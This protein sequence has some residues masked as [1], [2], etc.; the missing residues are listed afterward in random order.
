ML[1]ITVYYDEK[2]GIQ[3]ISNT[4][5]DLRPT[6]ENGEVYRDAEYKRLEKLSLLSGIDLL[7]KEEIPLVSE[8]HKSA[9]FIEFLKILEGKYPIIPSLTVPKSKNRCN[10][11][12]I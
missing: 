10:A 9:D 7:T 6:A 11:L 4:A 12:N 3:A 2:P 5:L 1:T 8:T